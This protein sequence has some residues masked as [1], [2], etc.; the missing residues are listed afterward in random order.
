[1]LS[2]QQ[3]NN[4]TLNAPLKALYGPY[5][6]LFGSTWLYKA[7]FG[8]IKL[9]LALRFLMAFKRPS[10]DQVRAFERPFKDLLKALRDL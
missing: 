1:M 4:S 3:S 10:K 6:A 5:K 7:L 9:Y 8:S 2:L